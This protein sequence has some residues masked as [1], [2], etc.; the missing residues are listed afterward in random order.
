MKLPVLLEM[1]IKDAVD[2]A[3]NWRIGR[4]TRHIEIKQY[5]LWEL[6]EEGLV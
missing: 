3:S 2:L 5:F 4:Q 1:D 6:E